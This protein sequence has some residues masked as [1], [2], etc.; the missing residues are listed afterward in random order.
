MKVLLQVSWGDVEAADAL[1]FFL[2]LN[3]IRELEEDVSSF[4]NEKGLHE[5][6]R[7]T[8]FWLKEE[9]A[10]DVFFSFNSGRS[11][12]KDRSVI[13]IHHFYYR[14]A[15]LPEEMCQRMHCWIIQSVFFLDSEVFHLK[16][17]VMSNKNQ[18]LRCNE[19]T[20]SWHPLQTFQF[21]TIEFY[22]CRVIHQS[23]HATISNLPERSKEVKTI[24]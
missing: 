17:Q 24:V 18:H 12:N 15:G 21:Y 14:Y 11:Q 8:F 16:D 3:F 19:S 23:S 2:F 5:G 10:K 1:L 7:E 6:E 22:R 13:D 4:H 9:E 20:E